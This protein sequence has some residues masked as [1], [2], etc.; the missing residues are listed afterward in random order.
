MF[1]SVKGKSGVWV[2]TQETGCLGPDWKPDVG[3]RKGEIG[4]RVQTQE[5]GCL[6]PDSGNLIFWSNRK[7]GVRI[8]KGETGCRVHIQE[9]GFQTVET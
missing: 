6:G 8:R 7:A 1:G 9:T 2:Q 4:C 5:T 3:V